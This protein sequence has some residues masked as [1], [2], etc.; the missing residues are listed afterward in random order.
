MGGVFCT[1]CALYAP[2]G[3]G[4]HKT[5]TG[6]FV[7]APF[8]G[9]THWVD[10]IDK[11]MS[12]HYHRDSAIQTAAFINAMHNTQ[13]DVT[14]QLDTAAQRQ[15]EENVK[16]WCQSSTVSYFLPVVV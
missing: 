2:K 13:K 10:D 14:A 11:H 12:R 1:Y 7:S 6:L 3:V 15:I 16:F 8:T 5:S 9:Y 4:R